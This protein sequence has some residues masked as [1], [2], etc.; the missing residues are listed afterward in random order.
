MITTGLG[1]EVEITFIVSFGFTIELVI[2]GYYLWLKKYTGK[3]HLG[4]VE[5]INLKK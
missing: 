2:N 4:L 1:L 3:Q 5:V